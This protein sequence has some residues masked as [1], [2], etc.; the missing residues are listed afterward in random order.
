MIMCT[1]HIKFIELIASLECLTHADF[2]K[3][4]LLKNIMDFL[5]KVI[6]KMLQNQL[7]LS[8]IYKVL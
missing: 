2:I 4:L 5:K 1:M 6:S 3:S 8:A 7:H